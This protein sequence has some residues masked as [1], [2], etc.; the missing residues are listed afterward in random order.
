MLDLHCHSNFSDGEFSPNELLKKAQELQLT[1]FSITDH[2]NCFAY[3]NMDR[4][5]F[6]GKLICGVEITTSFEEQIIEILGYG[7][8]IEPIN[9]WNA[10]EKIKQPQHAK[11]VYHK[12]LKLFKE[13]GISY[14][15]SEFIINHKCTTGTV[16]KYFYED[17]LKYEKNKKILGKEVLSSYSNFNKI[18]LNNPHSK[19]FISEYKDFLS[20]TQA[21]EFIHKNGGICF[22]AHIYQYDVMNH[23]VFLNNLLNIVKLDGVETCHSS[24]SKKQIIEINEYANTHGLYKS[25]G[26]D[27]H[28]ILKPGIELG[29][30]LEI[31]EDDIRIWGDK[32]INK[33]GV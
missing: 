13:Q 12:L 5:I 9:K 17:L 24:F 10:K 11:E 20:L 2:N 18:G 14:T 31:Q 27:F 8:D 19:L 21:V 29:K 16:K 15:K 30:N 6:S 7:I 26:S 23:I 22:L 4:S 3:E 32:I 33:K 28:G 25:G 1:Y